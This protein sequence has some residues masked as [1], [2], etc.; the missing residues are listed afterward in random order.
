MRNT[1]KEQLKAICRVVER[2]LKKKVKLAQKD[3]E[4]KK[5]RCL[6]GL[7]YEELTFPYGRRIRYRITETSS[8][9]VQPINIDVLCNFYL[10]GYTWDCIETVQ[11][12][13]S[14]MYVLNMNKLKKYMDLGA[15]LNESNFD[16]KTGRNFYDDYHLP[17][18][19]NAYFE[20][21]KYI[22]DD[23][24]RK[25]FDYVDGIGDT[26]RNIYVPLE[27]QVYPIDKFSENTLKDEC[28]GYGGISFLHL[29]LWSKN[30]ML[31][32]RF[33]QMLFKMCD[34][35][36]KTKVKR[37]IEECYLYGVT[38]DTRNAV[39]DSDP[40]CNELLSNGCIPLVKIEYNDKYGYIV[41]SCM[42]DINGRPWVR[43][44]TAHDFSRASDNGIVPTADD[45]PCIE[46]ILSR[47]LVI[48]LHGCLCIPIKSPSGKV[49]KRFKFNDF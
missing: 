32:K 15:V 30:E 22:R 38:D 2:V 39:M 33:N 3:F 17:Y 36:N 9:D 46:S 43:Y 16:K 41:H 45:I 27:L 21:D 5:F 6:S 1:D 49:D 25:E 4:N 19:K 7:K 23:I 12:N 44:F 11:S 47:W 20:D 34:L 37:V 10:G 48:G 18:M 13:D 26:N 42:F 14:I 29:L 31:Y 28:L 8:K 24:I 40:K 35:A